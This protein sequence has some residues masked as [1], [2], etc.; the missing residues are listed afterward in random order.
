M[1]GVEVRPR[2]LTAPDPVHGRGV[3]AAPLVGEGGPIYFEVLL[4]AQFFSVPDHGAS[5]VNDSAKDVEGEGF[6]AG[7]SH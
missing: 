6:H 5:P 3:A 2:D 7:D 4:L 1:E